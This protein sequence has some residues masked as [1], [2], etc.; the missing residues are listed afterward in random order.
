V[1]PFPG[2]GGTWR[3]TTEGGMYPQ[4]SGAGRELLFQNYQGKVMFAPYTVVGNSFQAGKPQIW[5]PTGIRGSA[6]GN[7]ARDLHP[8]GKR[9][10]VLAAKDE[11]DIVRDKV[12]F[13]SNFFDYL[14]K[15]APGTR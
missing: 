6:V 2:P 14:R 8:D 15:I 5:S 11:G 7:S 4:W 13:V 12:V 9:L 10:A 1:R 3:V